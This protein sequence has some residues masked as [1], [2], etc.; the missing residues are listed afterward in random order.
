MAVLETI[1]II[2]IILTVLSTVIIL[3][4]KNVDSVKVTLAGAT[5]SMLIFFFSTDWK[6]LLLS[7][8]RMEYVSD[9]FLEA[10]A[11]LVNVEALVIIFS[12]GIIV[13]LTK[14]AG[15]YD[16]VSLSI[17]RLTKGNPKLLMIYLGALSF[18]LSMFFDNLSAIILLGS[19]TIVI[20]K[21]LE[22]KPLPFVLYVAINTIIGG[23]PTPVSSLP[24]II[25]YSFYEQKIDFLSFTA[26]MF[27]IAIILHFVSLA[28]ILIAYKKE[29]NVEI[30]REKKYQIIHINPWSSIKDKTKI[31]RSI[32]V[33]VLLF[34]GFI[35]SSFIGLSVAFVALIV[36]ILSIFI[37]QSEL[38]K[39][40][41]KGIEWKM[42]V[43]FIGL[44][45]LMGIF[46]ATGALKPISALLLMILKLNISPIL[47]QAIVIGL[48]FI[49]GI[50]L[51]G[52]LNNTSAAIIYSFI[53]STLAS[54]I[55]G[56]I[57]GKGLW[58]SFVLAGNLGGLV[59]PLG[60]VTILMAIDILNKEG[61]HITFMDYV[62][63]VF[64]LTI[65]IVPI[66][67]AYSLILIA[68]GI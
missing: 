58:S 37:F 12:V 1:G 9:N 52:L 6:E 35:I 34:T 11:E 29:L 46:S 40:I 36:S 15:F 16:F 55:T 51:A 21:E 41:E 2:A 30:S 31:W 19:L 66:A 14:E 27:P 43:F 45:I 18:A 48:I 62:K 65:I 24:N 17:I 61:Y 42:I 59:T 44:F 39:Y 63:K 20:C 60:S 32:F 28:Y 47:A 25:F 7:N 54:K 3:M 56:T 5:L 26:L 10:I 53:Y 68:I 67:I 23:L 64:L 8:S 33:L 57:I 4:Q 50:P 13:S 38:E 49:I 22:L